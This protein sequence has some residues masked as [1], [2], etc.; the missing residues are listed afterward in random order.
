MTKTRKSANVAKNS[1]NVANVKNVVTNNSAT[2]ANVQT[3]EVTNEVENNLSLGAALAG[4]DSNYGVIDSSSVVKEMS[5]NDEVKKTS[6]L[7]S[8]KSRWR[9]PNLNFS[10]KLVSAYN[11]DKCY[12]PYHLAK[13][14][15][16]PNEVVNALGVGRCLMIWYGALTPEK[17]GEVKKAVNKDY[18]NDGFKSVTFHEF[19][20]VVYEHYKDLINILGFAGKDLEKYMTI[21]G[22]VVSWS[23]SNESGKR[24][25]YANGLYYDF[26]K[27][28]VGGYCSALSSLATY[29]NYMLRMARNKIN[30]N[31]YSYSNIYNFIQLAINDGGESNVVRACIDA[32]RASRAAKL[33]EFEAAKNKLKKRLNTIQDSIN[34]EWKI[35]EI[36]NKKITYFSRVS[37]LIDKCHLV[38]DDETGKYNEVVKDSAKKRALRLT[39]FYKPALFSRLTSD[40]KASRKRVER[41]Q[42]DYKS[43]KEEL[44]KLSENK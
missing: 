27:D 32:V 20:N 33:S 29:S 4:I 26:V 12:M 35:V 30:A 38:C 34:N 44:D 40:N 37:D 8:L 7:D 28:D 19:L 15:G 14:I 31:R 17:A 2:V 41:W 39:D 18:P 24:T 1:S 25:L 3:I 11:D 9:L 16:M 21:D 23:D 13:T 43:V 22:R 42:K 10:E 6:Y 36:R 5:I